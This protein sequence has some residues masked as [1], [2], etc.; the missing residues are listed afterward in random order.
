M[1]LNDHL[2]DLSESSFTFG[3]QCIPPTME[4]AS[5]KL[6]D[7]HELIIPGDFAVKSISYEVLH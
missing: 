5:V 7:D 2:R 4:L 6:M 1:G 3:T